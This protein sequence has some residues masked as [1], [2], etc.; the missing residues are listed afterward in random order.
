MDKGEQDG[1]I[2]GGYGPELLPDGGVEGVR[3]D[4]RPVH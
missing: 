1:R 2:S 4:Q 3:G